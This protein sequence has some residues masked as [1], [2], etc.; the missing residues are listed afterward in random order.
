MSSTLGLMTTTIIPQCKKE[1]R[2]I[3]KKWKNPFNVGAERPEAV[4]KLGE[5]H[6]MW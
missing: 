1:T 5:F 6:K 2:T 3:L 4:K